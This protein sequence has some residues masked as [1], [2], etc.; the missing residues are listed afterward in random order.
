MKLV[1][2]QTGKNYLALV[3]EERIHRNIKFE[4]QFFVNLE[5]IRDPVTIMF[6]SEILSTMRS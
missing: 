6:E 5:G 3:V 4:K 2:A 1:K